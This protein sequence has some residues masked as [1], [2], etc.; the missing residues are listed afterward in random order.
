MDKFQRA[1]LSERVEAAERKHKRAIDNAIR[2]HPMINELDQKI[3]ALREQQNKFTAEWERVA[4]AAIERENR[5]AM[6]Y[7]YFCDDEE[8]TMDKVMEYEDKGFNALLPPP[9]QE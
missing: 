4:Y 3:E 9:E 7:I 1:H 8:K 6:N 2:N 5:L